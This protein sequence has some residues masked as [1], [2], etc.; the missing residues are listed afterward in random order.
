MFTMKSGWCVW[1]DRGNL[2]LK[3]IQAELIPGSSEGV[4]TVDQYLQN[5][6]SYWNN[7]NSTRCAPV[8]GTQWYQKC[9][10]WSK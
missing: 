2:I 9:Q 6:N 3:S 10:D 8:G 7:S 5:Y 1:Q 4:C